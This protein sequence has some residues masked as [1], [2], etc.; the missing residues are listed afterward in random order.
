M[1]R[2][3]LLIISALLMTAQRA[4]ADY[5]T[6]IVVIGHN[7]GKQIGYLYDNYKGAGWICLEKDLNDGAG[8][9]YIHLVYKTNKS[10]QNS[11]TPITDL[12]LWS[13]PNAGPASLVHNGR[14]YYRVGAD[15]DGDF[16]SRNGD[17]NCEAGGNWIQ[18]YYTKDKFPHHR[19]LTGISVDENAS[20]CVGEN[21]GSTPGD[22]NRGAGGD[23]IFLHFSIDYENWNDHRASS[24]SHT[25]G[26]T[27]Y[28][29][30]EEE[31]ALLGYKVTNGTSYAG[32]V[33]VLNRDLD[34]SEYAWTPMGYQYETTTPNQVYGWDHVH[35][36]QGFRGSFDGRWH[37]I[38]GLFVNHSGNEAGLFGCIVGHYIDFQYNE[39]RN[40]NIIDAD[41]HGQDHVGILSGYTYSCVI[42]KNVMTQGRVS[43]NHDVGGIVGYGDAESNRS[44]TYFFTVVIID[45][46]YLGGSQAWP[47]YGKHDQPSDVDDREN[48]YANYTPTGN[49]AIRLSTVRRQTP[50]EGISFDVEYSECY[51]YNGVPYCKPG[52]DVSYTI[53]YNAI[54]HDSVRTWVN[55]ESH[56]LNHSFNVVEGTDY[57]IRVECTNT[58]ITGSGSSADPYILTTDKHWSHLVNLKNQGRNYNGA[59][60]KLGADISISAAMPEFVGTFDGNGHT[61]TVNLTA[62]DD[63]CAPFSIARNATFK[64]L[65]VAGTITTDKNRSAGLVGVAYG[66]T[67]ITNCRSSVS[68]LSSTAGNGGHGGFVGSIN[69]EDTKVRIDGCL[70]DGKILSVGD[71]ATTDCGGLVGEKTNSAT[72]TISNSIYDPAKLADGEN[73]ATNNS[74]TLV[75]VTDGVNT[76][77]VNCGYNR[78]LGMI[79]GVIGN[80][81]KSEGIGNIIETYSVSGIARYDL[82]L[83]CNG[84]WY[85]NIL[86]L[87]LADNAPNSSLISETAS[88]YSGHPLNT[89]LMGRSFYTDNKWNTLCLPFDVPLADSPL[90][91]AE[92]RTLTGA[93]LIGST[94]TLNF[95]EPVETLTAG[96][97]YII[98]LDPETAHDIY[99][100]RSAEDWNDFAAAVESGKDFSQRT[101]NL[102][103]DITVSTP[104]GS[105][106]H[107]FTGTFDGNGH[108]LT[109]NSTASANYWAPFHYV[110]DATI[111]NL[112]VA[113]TIIFS[114]IGVGSGLVGINSGPLTIDNCRVSVDFVD[115]KGGSYCGGFVNYISPEKG[116]NITNSIFDG[117]FINES[118]TKS[119][120]A[121]FK[122]AVIA[123]LTHHT[124]CL[125]KPRNIAGDV[126]Y[127][128]FSFA[129]MS[130]ATFTNCYYSEEFPMTMTQGTP[131]G[132]M[133]SEQLAAALGDGW[134]VTDGEV[135]PVMEETHFLNI[136]KTPAFDDVKFT[137]IEPARITPGLTAGTEGDGCVTFAGTY[138]PVEIG[139]EG[140][141]T[142]LYFSDN[143]TLY[144]PNGAM[145][146]N[147]FRAYFQLN[148]TAATRGVVVNFGD[149]NTTG[150]SDA[151]RLNDKEQMINDNWYTLDGRKIA[152]GQKP[153]AKGLYIKNGKKYIIK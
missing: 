17:L 86:N 107:P 87:E 120:F 26:N 57:T 43:G 22:L 84:L 42:I 29:E 94:L 49:K 72:L 47:I 133:S 134:Q 32:N 82:D 68:I 146:I 35:V 104:V 56:G 7:S 59:Y 54:I 60:F 96:T 150:I 24:F 98:R 140:D 116:Q 138:D 122:M 38:R 4:W 8:G 124:N 28:I 75:R 110:K 114:S 112:H 77:I 31:L 148:T 92:A 89:K 105:T 50:P 76:S 23:D 153:T 80:D 126:A 127:T 103:S 9:H 137:A 108:T 67:S 64:N 73:E 44:S 90:A 34:L 123:D 117:T 125:S 16:T 97:P 132:S 111:K 106:N 95:S 25:E 141:N 46:A 18:L 144:W 147:P 63:Y 70:F 45:C 93:S 152:N 51:W 109:F 33:V 11:G 52:S 48:Y 88:L 1:K 115:K 99:T 78:P 40:L 149:G 21:G 101:V 79:Q 5:V 6:D 53:G 119:T 145:T 102:V 2:L 151:M 10:P 19:Y 58:G 37:T 65:H 69:K 91:G 62:D 27:I 14:T 20:G 131:V 130:N 113:G 128:P 142:K 74:A 41:V 39:I 135:L 3:F 100:I 139:E 61:M 129:M 121:G 71:V 83:E 66:N 136:I 15:G 85:K 36:L 13:A 118:N 12:Y 81:T 143:N 30:N 55:N